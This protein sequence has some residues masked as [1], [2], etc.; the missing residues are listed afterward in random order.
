MGLWLIRIETGFEFIRNNSDWFRN[1]FLNGSHWFGINSQSE[2]FAKVLDYCPTSS[3][4]VSDNEL[5]PGLILPVPD[6]TQSGHESTRPVPSQFP[7]MQY[8]PSL[9]VRDPARNL[10]VMELTGAISTRVVLLLYPRFL[11][12]FSKNKYNNTRFYNEK[13]LRVLSASL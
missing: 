8:S 2:T 13:F 5:H 10:V 9:P 7:A 6:L 1:I 12:T 3:R 11:L 4:S